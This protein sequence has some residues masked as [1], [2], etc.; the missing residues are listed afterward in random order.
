M[1]YQAR[2]QTHGRTQR[3]NIVAFDFLFVLWQGA[4]AMPRTLRRLKAIGKG[5]LA[6]AA[7][8]VEAGAE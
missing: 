3:S 8:A 5:I 2:L 7:A 6:A 1:I 4:M